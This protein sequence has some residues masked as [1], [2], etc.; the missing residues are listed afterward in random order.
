MFNASVFSPIAVLAMVYFLLAVGSIS[1]LFARSSALG[2]LPARIYLLNTAHGPLMIASVLLGHSVA[3]LWCLVG[4]IAA[5]AL[6]GVQLA[7]ERW[8][9]YL[10]A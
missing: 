5:C 3:S 9:G 4:A 1:L 8:Y 10:S 7:L 6:T 2:R